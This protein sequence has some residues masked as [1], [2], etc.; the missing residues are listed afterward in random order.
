MSSVRE[1]ER[2]PA[3]SGTPLFICVVVVRSFNYIQDRFIGQSDKS[4]V[5]LRQ[6]QLRFNIVPC[7]ALITATNLS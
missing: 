6:R 2:D 4:P 7:V 3:R 1:C 5:C